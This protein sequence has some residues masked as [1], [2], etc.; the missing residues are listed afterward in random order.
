[1]QRKWMLSVMVAM[2][3]VVVLGSGCAR[4]K[5]KPGVPS[6]GGAQAELLGPMDEYG[7]QMSDRFEDGELIAGLNFAN[8]QFGYNQYQVTGAEVAKIE[9]VAQY[10]NANSN[11]R[12]I[13]EG[14][15]DE[16][17]SREYNIALGE[18]R[19]Q[20]VRSYLMSLGIDGS[21][22]QT[23]SYGEERPLDPGHN[24]SAWS[25]N[26]RAEFALYR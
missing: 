24:E 13:V 25:L 1:M 10:M 19:A 2:M 7:Y 11:V 4:K 3:A 22:I 21:R 20:A 23:R 16:R 17:G 12:L 18:H 26:R 15:C 5:P 6:G 8:V 14:H 9:A